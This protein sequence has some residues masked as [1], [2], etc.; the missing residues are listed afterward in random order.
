MQLLDQVVDLVVFL[1]AVAASHWRVGRFGFAGFAVEGLGAFGLVERC[2][3]ERSHIVLSGRGVIGGLYHK[4]PGHSYLLD[5]T[6]PSGPLLGG[7]LWGGTGGFGG[8]LTPAFGFRGRVVPGGLWRELAR[9]G[10]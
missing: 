1:E 6:V 3:F 8:G 7:L 5:V 10:V 2:A 9:V 4:P